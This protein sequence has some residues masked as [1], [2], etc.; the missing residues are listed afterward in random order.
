M[1]PAITAAEE[2][3]TPHPAAGRKV[4]AIIVDDELLAR[5]KIRQLLASAPDMEVIGE[6]DNGR[7]AIRLIHEHRPQL[8]FLDIQMPEMSGFD[9]LKALPEDLRPATIFVTGHQQ[10]AV[11]AFEIHAVDYLLKPITVA[12]FLEALQRVR[13]HL[14]AHASETTGAS[15]GP[16][17]IVHRPSH[18]SVKAGKRTVFV[19]VEEIDFVESAANYAIL[20][21]GAQT[22][23]LRETLTNLEAKL[24]THRFMR[25]SRSVIVNLLF[26][27]RAQQPSPRGRVLGTKSG[28][29]IPVTCSLREIR[30]RLE[31]SLAASRFA[32]AS[33][34]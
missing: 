26:V 11:K 34:A 18:I 3:S 16:V 19:P 12:R 33:R 2:G 24:P 13:Q 31:P 20:H 4:R 7:D 14:P 8:L 28:K 6:A 10:H 5:A 32:S 1:N 21:V 25:V 15:N 17:E 29:Q 27:A 9:V 23:I 22:H 30:R